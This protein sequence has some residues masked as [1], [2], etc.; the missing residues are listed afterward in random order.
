MFERYTEKARRTIFFARYEASQYGA[1]EIESEHLLLGILR[2]GKAALNAILGLTQIEDIRVQ[3]ESRS[4]IGPKIMASIDL[5]LTNECKRIL[6]YGAE[7]SMRMSQKHIGIEH[8]LIGILREDKCLAAK[9][10]HKQGLKLDKA[11]KLIAEARDQLA[12]SASNP[13]PAQAVQRE[14]EELPP[15]RKP[16]TIRVVL[17]C[18]SEILI[19][20]RSHFGPPRIGESIRMHSD[21]GATYTYRVQDVVWELR[22]DESIVLKE[23]NVQVVKV[24]TE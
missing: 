6:A 22:L 3:I 7:E 13:V 23:V 4:T 18:E 20:Y 14:L 17:T 10:L 24:D 15:T 21:D 19:A 5:P 2:E 1:S 12:T 9:I 8:L 16:V 11:R